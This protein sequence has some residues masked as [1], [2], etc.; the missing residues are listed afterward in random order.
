MKIM[1]S[2]EVN[3]AETV[4][5]ELSLPVTP[6]QFLVDFRNQAKKVLGNCN[7]MPGTMANI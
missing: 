3:A 4:V 6:E 7:M 1:G 2:R 5:K